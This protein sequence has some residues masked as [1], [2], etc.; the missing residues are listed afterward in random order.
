MNVPGPGHSLTA[1]RIMLAACGGVGTDAGLGRGALGPGENALESVTR[2]GV[3]Q[4][5]VAK[6]GRQAGEQQQQHGC[7]TVLISLE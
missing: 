3:D 6:H 1:C 2:H 5:A 7:H 4:R